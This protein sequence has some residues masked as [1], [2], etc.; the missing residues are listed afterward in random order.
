MTTTV[1]ASGAGLL[2]GERPRRADAAPHRSPGFIWRRGLAPAAALAGWIAFTVTL[3]AQATAGPIVLWNDSRAYEAVAAHPLISLA[4]WAGKEPPLVPLLIKV[5]G[6]ST[7]YQTA[8]ALIAAACWGAL[9]WTVGRLVER[10]WRRVAATWM[11][12]AFATAFPITLW[13]RSLLSE[14]LALSTLALVFAAVIWTVRAPTWP[15]MAATAAA[16]FLFAASRDAQIWTVGF[17]AVSAAVCAVVR[18]RKAPDWARRVAV[19]ALML[20]LVVG[21]AEWATVSSHRTASDVEDVLIVRVFPYPSRV[22]WFAAHGMPEERQVDALARA[23]PTPAT[24]KV[25]AIPPDDP[26][27]APLRRWMADEASGTYVFWL[28]THPWYVISEPLERPEQAY[29]F[30]GG[31]LTFYAASDTPVPSPLTV[32]VWPP[33][34][35][36]AA[37]GVLA[38][39]LAAISGVWREWTWRAVLVLAGLGIPAMLVAW[40]GD[41]QE[42][43]RHTVEGFAELHLGVWILLVVGLLRLR[44]RSSSS[45]GQP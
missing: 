18:M 2:T 11:V 33:L 44:R 13:N 28:A 43:T 25:V 45:P 19:L 12:L 1:G 17:L 32:V 4:F 39:G 3:L 36:L 24:A 29:N 35:G 37:M 26:A 23:T 22:A 14:A 15:R 8:Q 10:G 27:F 30:A 31:S 42:V 41:G 16:C 20:A 5:V 38:V 34:I 21:M 9:A 40:H 7:G 6:T